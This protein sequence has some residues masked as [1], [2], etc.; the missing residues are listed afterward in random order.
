[1]RSFKLAPVAC[2][3]LHNSSSVFLTMIA[4]VTKQRWA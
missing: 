1:M 4:D 2:L 3:S